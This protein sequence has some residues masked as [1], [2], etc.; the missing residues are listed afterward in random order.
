MK[1]YKDINLIDDLYLIGG[2]SIL[3]DTVSEYEREKI[4]NICFGMELFIDDKQLLPVAFS[5]Q[6]DQIKERKYFTYYQFTIENDGNNDQR[7]GV[8]ANG[9]LVETPSVNQFQN[10]FK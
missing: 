7:F 3:V 6:F 10:L 4:I 5:K 9:I 2:H 8:W 1:K